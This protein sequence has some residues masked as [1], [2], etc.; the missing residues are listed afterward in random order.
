MCVLRLSATR[1]KRVS[2]VDHLQGLFAD[3]LVSG[4]FQWMQ[5]SC[6]PNVEAESNLCQTLD[7]GRRKKQKTNIKGVFNRT[8]GSKPTCP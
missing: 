1:V 3:A 7:Q 5:H 8:V 4:L 6:R 2:K